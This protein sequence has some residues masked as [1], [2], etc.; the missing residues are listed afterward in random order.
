MRFDTIIERLHLRAHL[1]HDNG[2][3]GWKHLS[4]VVLAYHTHEWCVRM[5]F[6]TVP[7]GEIFVVSA[8]TFVWPLWCT[9]AFLALATLLYMRLDTV[10]G[11]ATGIELFASL[12]GAFWLHEYAAAALGLTS[13]MA[14]ALVAICGLLASFGTTPISHGYFE[15]G[16]EDS[17]P[18][19]FLPNLTS[20]ALIP[21]VNKLQFLYYCRLYRSKSTWG[22]LDAMA[23]EVYAARETRP[24][25]R[26]PVHTEPCFV[27]RR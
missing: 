27:E 8:L 3:I 17:L 5:H 13:T 20:K 4:A 21:F 1:S 7:A 23:S 25:P 18:M 12:G 22:D 11:L 10:V 9:V 24:A 2:P 15:E 6:V 19:E 14:H 26:Y 16:V